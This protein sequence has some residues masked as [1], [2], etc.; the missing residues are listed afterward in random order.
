MKILVTGGAGY[1]GTQLVK[2]V[3][4]NSE[5]E[6]VVVYDNL[7]RKNFNLF[8]GLP[9]KNGHKV[10][11]VSGDI[12]DSRKFRKALKGIDVVYHLAANVSTPY[13]DINSH[14]FEQ[15][16]HWGTAE[17]VSAVEE[18]DVKQFV[19][20]SSASVYGRTNGLVEEDT[21]PNPK[22]AYGISK[23]RGEE[24]VRRLMSK[25][26][27]YILRCA[28]V[29]GYSKSMRF[30]A[31]IN[32][33]MF[34]AHYSNRISINGSG[35]QHRPFIHID[36]LA[37][38][39]SEIIIKDVPSGTYNLVDKNLQ[40]LDVVDAMKEIYPSLEFI[41]TNQHLDLDGLQLSPSAELKKYIPYQNYES[42]YDE[43]MRFKTRF[44]F[45]HGSYSSSEW[46]FSI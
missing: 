43:L 13:S 1:I 21:T 33:F 18:A 6:E 2:S 36:T 9:M 39:L 46:Y 32:R 30:D 5:V 3:L 31:V 45:F 40:I 14:V 35:K 22:T 23:S 20:V 34:E 44:S 16:N 42:L 12:L 41:F 15:V 37:K 10:K 24:H 28:N 25:M 17:V 26:D 11:F 8:L 4:D 7:S 38:V 29:Y 27:A 19:Y